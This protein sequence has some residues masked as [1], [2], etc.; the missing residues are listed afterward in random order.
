MIFKNLCPNRT[1]K[2]ATISEHLALEIKTRVF[3]ISVKSLITL[4]V[5]TLLLYIHFCA[6]IRAKETFESHMK[7]NNIDQR[8]K[9]NYLFFS[10]FV[11]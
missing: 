8:V 3:R 6:N 5:S 2:T 9:Q 7:L 11:R 1:D 10:Q 4:E